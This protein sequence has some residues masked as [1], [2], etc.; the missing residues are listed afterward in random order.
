MFNLEY[1]YL[2]LSSDHLLLCSKLLTP[3]GPVGK[4]LPASAEDTGFCLKDCTEQLSQG[5]VGIAEAGR[6]E[7]VSATREATAARGRLS[8]TAQQPQA[9]ESLSTIKARRRPSSA[10]INK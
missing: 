2:V 1:S 8:T 7:P 10:K 5:S 3:G 9:A 4:S 6:R